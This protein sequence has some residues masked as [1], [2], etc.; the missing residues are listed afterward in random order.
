MSAPSASTVT[1]RRS[2]AAQAARLRARTSLRHPIARHRVLVIATLDYIMC[3]MTMSRS[4]D[5]RINS[6]IISDKMT[7]EKAAA[8]AN[9]TAAAMK[10]TK[11]SDGRPA[12]AT[13]VRTMGCTSA[14]A[15]TRRRGAHVSIVEQLRTWRL[16]AGGVP[17]TG[18]ERGERERDFARLAFGCPP[19][20]DGHP[21]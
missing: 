13:A 15:A 8:G 3:S 18:G 6:F 10:R 17:S 11:T 4:N 20:W 16:H 2:A 19:K 5:A 12:M 9:V 1:R 14:R 7:Q 21:S